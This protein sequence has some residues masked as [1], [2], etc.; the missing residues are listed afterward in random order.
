MKRLPT[1]LRMWRGADARAPCAFEVHECGAGTL[2]RGWNHAAVRTPFWHLYHNRQPGHAI[3][4]AGRPWPLSPS[5][6]LL[7]PPDFVY[8]CNGDRPVDHLWIHFSLHPPW[9]ATLSEPLAVPVHGALQALLAAG[10]AAAADAG[11]FAWL[12]QS[13]LD[14]VFADPAVLP[15]VAP[16][17]RRL[18]ALLEHVEAHP[19]GDLRVQTLARLCGRSPES[20]TRWFHAE[21]GLTPSL[22]VRR[23]RLRKAAEWLAYGEASIEQIAEAAGFSDRFHLSRCFAAAYACGPATF[24]KR[25]RLRSPPAARAG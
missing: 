23:S 2:T 9:A 1:D 3:R 17:P 4:S 22:H 19:G 5:H 10:R 24:R 21:L 7:L 16:P 6:A 12:C 8:D 14:L 15:G 11:R 18:Q 25:A 13:M 20:F